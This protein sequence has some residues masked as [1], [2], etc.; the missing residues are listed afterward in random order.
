[1]DQNPGEKQVNE[2]FYVMHWGGVG[3]PSIWNR[4]DV[5][6]HLN[7]H[8]HESQK[9]KRRVA[10]YNEL[11]IHSSAC[12][13]GVGPCYIFAHAHNIHSM[14]CW[15]TSFL[16]KMAPLFCSDNILFINVDPMKHGLKNQKSLF[17]EREEGSRGKESPCKS[18]LIHAQILTNEKTNQTHH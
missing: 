1:M 17:T 8:F 16:T 18:I 12:M 5:P 9:V 2:C 7:Q 4:Q 13:G 11:L 10:L 3:V 15:C 6:L 14:F